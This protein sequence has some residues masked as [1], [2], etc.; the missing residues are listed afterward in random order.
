MQLAKTDTAHRQAEIGYVPA[1]TWWGHGYATEAT[2]ALMGF[3]FDQLG[4]REVSAGCD[5]ANVAS[6]RVLTKIGM[7]PAGYRHNHLQIRGQWRDRLLF[8]AT[9]TG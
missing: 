1:R 3:G 5:P 4:L 2:Q 8:A 6:A 9:S 7:R